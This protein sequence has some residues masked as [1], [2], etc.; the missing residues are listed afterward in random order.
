[1]KVEEILSIVSSV[2]GVSERDITGT[3]RRTETVIARHLS[4]WASRWNT[5]VPLQRIAAV[6]NLAQHGTVIH[7]AKS[8]DNQRRNNQKIDTYCQH[9]LNQINKQCTT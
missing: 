4:L 7:A 9:I 5:T 2:T 1:M 6:H 3:S 8:I